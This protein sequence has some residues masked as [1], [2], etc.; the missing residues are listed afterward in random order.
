MSVSSNAETDKEHKEHARRTRRNHRT[1]T[2]VMFLAVAVL[3]WYILENGGVDTTQEIIALFTIVAG[4]ATAFQYLAMVDQNL[5]MRE[6]TDILVKQNEHMAKQTE[7]MIAQNDAIEF[8][9]EQARLEQRAWLAFD[10]ANL[11]L[12]GDDPVK[13]RVIIKNSG[14]TPGEITAIKMEFYQTAPSVNPVTF[15]KDF[16]AK[17]FEYTS[18]Y[19][20]APG[21]KLV[22]TIDAENLLSPGIGTCFSQSTPVHVIANFQYRD[23]W[24]RIHELKV[25]YTGTDGPM[26][27]RGGYS[28]MD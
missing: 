4:L 22:I 13:C 11:V 23:I 24:K 28:S 9:V 3:T 14:E 12:V 7:T 15:L 6:Q 16:E 18:C 10:S 26:H 19:V 27:I 17:E 25:I 20:V 1:G 2:V 21:A 5:H 8:Q